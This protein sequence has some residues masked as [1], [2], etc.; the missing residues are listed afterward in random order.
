VLKKAVVNYHEFVDS[1]NVWTRRK[2]H[3]LRSNWNESVEYHISW[4][5][6]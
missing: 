2:G 4:S 6:V 1:V 3:T 5:Y